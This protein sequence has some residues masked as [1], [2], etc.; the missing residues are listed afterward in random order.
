MAFFNK[1]IINHAC[2]QAKKGALTINF[3]LS[4][5][6]HRLQE[7]LWSQVNIASFIIGYNHRG[8]QTNEVVVKEATMGRLST[9]GKTP[10]L[11]TKFI[12]RNDIYASV[13]KWFHKNPFDTKTVGTDLK[14]INLTSLQLMA[15]SENVLQVIF[16]QKGFLM[17]QLF[18]E[19]G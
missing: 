4:G 3:T 6:F 19:A 7:E 8:Y 15:E 16:M 9:P 5:S 1:K 13:R 11:E 12:F 10:S 17:L 2:V 14:Q 18:N